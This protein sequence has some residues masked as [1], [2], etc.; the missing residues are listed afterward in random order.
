MTIGH[1]QSTINSF[2]QQLTLGVAALSNQVSE[3]T[4][5]L[6]FAGVSFDQN[7]NCNDVGPALV[8]RTIFVAGEW[9]PFAPYP[10]V[11]Q[12]YD[13]RQATQPSIPW[14]IQGASNGIWT[15]IT[16]DR[17][18]AMQLGAMDPSGSRSNSTLFEIR[19]NPELVTLASATYSATATKP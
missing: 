16:E 1:F 11:G 6:V 12:Y 10:D 3:H 17:I 18:W 9:Y 8:D 2:Q 15:P 19:S 5:A 7:G 13:V 14:D 4:A